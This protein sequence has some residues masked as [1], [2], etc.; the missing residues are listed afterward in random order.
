LLNQAGAGV[1]IV[2]P[3]T[4]T[5]RPIRTHV[6]VKPPEGGL[7]RPSDIMCEAIRSVSTIRLGRKRGEVSD[8]TMRAVEE[9][10]YFLMDLARPIP[11]QRSES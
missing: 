9:R 10:L 7:D 1:V 5:T 6:F 11:R 3:I 2:I 8:Q 4:G